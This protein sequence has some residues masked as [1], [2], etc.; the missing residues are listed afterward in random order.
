MSDWV[1]MAFFVSVLVIIA[2]GEVV[3]RIIRN[4][5]EGR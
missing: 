1:L 5:R 2:I 3:Y 4:K